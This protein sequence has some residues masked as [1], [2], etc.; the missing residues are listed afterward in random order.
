MSDQD[1]HLETIFP[2]NLKQGEI[3][4]QG[5]A[6]VSGI[7]IGIPVF[8]KHNESKNEKHETPSQPTVDKEIELFRR[9]VAQNQTELQE[10]SNSLFSA[11]LSQEADLVE[12]SLF[13]ATDPILLDQVEEKIRTNGSGHGRG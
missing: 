6:V 7:A 3:W 11:G 1:K 4:L 8:L 2:N 10:L 13:L 9:A 5:K 12:A